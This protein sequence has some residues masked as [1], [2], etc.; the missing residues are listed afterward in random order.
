MLLKTISLFLP[1]FPQGN[2]CVDVKEGAMDT[3]IETNYCTGQMDEDSAG[4]DSRASTTIIRYNKVV[5][6]KGAGVRLGGHKVGPDQY[7]IACQVGCFL[8][9]YLF[10]VFFFL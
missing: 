6:C 9:I 2:E 7:G 3:I 4:I 5:G 10:Y 8:F 1:F